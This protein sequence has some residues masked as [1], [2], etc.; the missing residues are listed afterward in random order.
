MCIL[1]RIDWE[2]ERARLEGLYAAMSEAELQEV[3]DDADSLTAVA[4]GALRA[5][6][7]RRGMKAPPETATTGEQHEAEPPRPKPVVV[8]RYRDL[9]TASIA[10]SILD[11]AGME[12]FLAD[13]SVIR[14]DWLYSNALGGIKLL[15]RDEDAAAARDLLET[16]IPEKFDVDG[17]GEYHQPKCPN[18]GSLDVSFEELDREIAHPGLLIGI[19]IPAVKHG[20][21]C[22]SCG[23]TWDSPTETPAE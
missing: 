1:T 7:L 4:R 5:E 17:V 22:H 16:Q 18:C 11:S 20:W 15:V 9:S 12:S 3:A 23:H 21:N 6:M 2:K 8:G 14:L 10:K 13:D 19:P